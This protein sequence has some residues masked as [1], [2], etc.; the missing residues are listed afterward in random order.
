MTPLAV[1]VMTPLA[2]VAE[3]VSLAVEADFA[4][5]EIDFVMIVACS[6]V[7]FLLVAVAGMMLVFGETMQVGLAW[8]G[9]LAVYI[10]QVFGHVVVD[11]MAIDL[12]AADLVVVGAVVVEHGQ[13]DR[14]VHDHE[15]KDHVVQIHHAVIALGM[16]LDVVD[17]FVQTVE[18]QDFEVVD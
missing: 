4:L 13:V 7:A 8:L 18:V 10:G 17:V 1:A 11:L 9:V 12:V 16:V 5:M 14:E 2:V 3:V 15:P 6:V